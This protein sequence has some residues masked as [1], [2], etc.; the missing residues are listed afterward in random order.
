MIK[1]FSFGVVGDGAVSQVLDRNNVR[2]CGSDTNATRIGLDTTKE[3]IQPCTEICGYVFP[4][5]PASQ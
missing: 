4:V 5:L 2:R 1:G 3:Y